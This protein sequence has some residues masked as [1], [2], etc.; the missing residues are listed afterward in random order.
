M[1]NLFLSV[2]GALEEE[3]EVWGDCVRREDGEGK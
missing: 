3:S 2:G 1:Q